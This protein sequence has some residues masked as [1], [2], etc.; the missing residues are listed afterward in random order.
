MKYKEGDIVYYLDTDGVCRG[1]VFQYCDTVK[2]YSIQQI[3][4]QGWGDV[5]VYRDECE[6]YESKEKLLEALRR[7]IE[8]L[9]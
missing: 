4:V 1:E 9:G 3:E 6:I 2:A 7:Q 8:K 5:W